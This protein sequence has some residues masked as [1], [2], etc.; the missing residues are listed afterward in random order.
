M[1][2]YR[3]WACYA[4]DA[5]QRWYNP[6]T[7]LWKR[8]GWWNSSHALTAVI[9]H[10]QRTGEHRHRYVI[11]TTLAVPGGFTGFQQRVLRR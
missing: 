2:Q 11:E 3:A 6:R 8:A 7:G 10:S 1:D 5:L 9:Q 4:A